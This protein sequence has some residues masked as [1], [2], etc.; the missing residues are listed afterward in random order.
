[1]VGVDCKRVLTLVWAYTA[2]YTSA[3]CQNRKPSPPL[4]D[5]VDHVDHYTY[6]DN[7]GQEKGILCE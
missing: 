5:H 4:D 2:R 3:V 1:M 6:L 7:R